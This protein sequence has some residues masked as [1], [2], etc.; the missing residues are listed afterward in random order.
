MRDTR[1]INRFLLDSGLRIK[2]NP[3]VSP[4][5]CLDPAALARAVAEALPPL[6]ELLR[7]PRA[8]RGEPRMRVAAG[9]VDLYPA[10]ELRVG[11][12]RLLVVEERGTGDA[13][14]LVE[15]S[16]PIPLP[17]ALGLG[18]SL[19]LVP[20][21]WEGLAPLKNLLLEDDPSSTVFPVARGTLA[22][23]SL[24]IGARFTT[25]HWG[26][27]AWVMKALG[28]SLTAN[29]N[30]IPRELVYDVDAMLEGRL[31]EVPF[32]FVGGSVPEGHQGQ[33][34]QGMTHAA[35]V[36]FLKCGFHRH[37]IPWGFNA[38]HQPIG[39]R[40][41]AIEEE[42]ARGCAFASYITFD[43]SPELAASEPPGGPDPA[44]AAFEAPGAPELFERVVARLAP[45][46]LALDAAEAR[47][48]FATLLP[49]MRKLKRR[50]E[51][52][53]RVRGELFTTDLGRRYFREL[54]IDELPGR[55]SPG[56]LAV[57]LALAEALGVEVHYVAPAIGFQKNF[58]YPDDAGLRQT[59]EAVAAVARSFGASIG[60][61]SGSGKS[62]ENYRVAGEVTRLALEVK[63]SGRYTY[64][65][66]V[67]LSRSSDPGDAALWRD[68]YGFTRDL[69]VAGA[70]SGDP[71]R[72]RFARDF[73]RH[74]L[75]QEGLSVGGAFDSPAALREALHA[76]APS[77]DHMFFF[78][79]NFLYVLAGAGSADRLGD[80]GP[81]G[82]AQRAR[83][84]G[85]SD[86]ARLL[87][88]KGVAAYVLFLAGTTGL[89]PAARVVAARERLLALSS[90]DAFERDLVA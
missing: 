40:F 34:V 19:S 60:F 59:V 89:A 46:G 58:P 37:R 81:D 57:A 27:V 87:Y 43:L 56:T 15:G 68:W 18:D 12:W 52:Y 72:Q 82:Y 28:L 76:L 4:D 16:D 62:A 67:A 61:H 83:F 14:L 32:P 75:K 53:A 2:G 86:E 78:E 17:G 74:A 11:P 36:A 5:L 10:S 79:Y 77:P 35:V 66:G 21:L 33:S 48:L 49:A 38:D 73:V 54:S 80:H 44:A 30:S 55:T 7:A 39:G 41:D 1:A 90:H 85:V 24:G 8:F 51:A 9:P 71:V 22:R 6:A 63:T 84:Y 3:A 64:E 50:D 29:Q 25:L 13:G 70:F 20:L 23:S 26:A 47:R 88:A 45:L 65:M 69:A 31:A 42:L